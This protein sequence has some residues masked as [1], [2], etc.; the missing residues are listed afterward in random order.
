MGGGS[1]NGWYGWECVPWWMGWEVGGIGENE[2]ESS[3]EEQYKT[4]QILFFKFSKF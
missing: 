2:K 1:S 3:G 4:A